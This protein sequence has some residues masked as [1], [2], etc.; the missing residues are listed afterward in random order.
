MTTTETKARAGAD[1]PAGPEGE[2]ALV[3]PYIC[4]SDNIAMRLDLH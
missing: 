4:R 1:M 3:A 2:E